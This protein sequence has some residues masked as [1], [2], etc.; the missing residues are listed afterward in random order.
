MVSTALGCGQKP[1]LV[2]W[3]ADGSEPPVAGPCASPPPAF[4]CSFAPSIEQCKAQ[5]LN[6]VRAIYAGL[7]T[8][9]TTN[10]PTADVYQT[11]L[12]T[13]DS[14]WCGYHPDVGG[15]AGMSR[16]CAVRKQG[17]AVAFDCGGDPRRCAR[18]VAQEHGHLLG[19]EHTTGA[20]DIM[21]GTLANQASR[22]ADRDLAIAE[23]RCQ[24]TTQNS[25]RLLKAR[26]D[27]L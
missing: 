23:P 19:L 22:F 20:P 21:N 14:R 11:V 4:R 12:I 16:H 24:A 2:L 27:E 5:I 8:E 26:L 6:E 13:S 17:V 18:I 15:I 25:Y 10:L 9:V 1:K 7:P 3:F